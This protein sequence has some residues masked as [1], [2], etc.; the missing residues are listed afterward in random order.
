MSP[1]CTRAR[2]SLFTPRTGARRQLELTDESGAHRVH[3][4]AGASRSW[5]TSRRLR[6]HARP[7]N[8][9]LASLCWQVTAAV[10]RLV[11]S[12]DDR[13]VTRSTC[14]LR[15]ETRVAMAGWSAQ[16]PASAVCAAQLRE[17]VQN[18]ARTRC[19]RTAAECL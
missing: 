2:T 6:C 17:T 16:S 10:R 3:R 14:A 8:D 15:A 18:T 12:R 5:L 9:V 11:T 7:G 13:S 1:V 4:T 19:D